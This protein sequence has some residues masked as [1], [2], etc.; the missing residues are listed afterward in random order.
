M[1]QK[2]T[3]DDLNKLE[4]YDGAPVQCIAVYDPTF[5]TFNSEHMLDIIVK[6]FAEKYEMT[7]Y[8]APEYTRTTYA[9]AGLS[10]TFLY[11][12]PSGDLV[13][14]AFLKLRRATFP[15]LP[16]DVNDIISKHVGGEK[17]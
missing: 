13:E 7:Y 2:Y 10:N 1:K 4:Y 5:L 16:H 9:G 14:E 3:F 15:L 11:A 8:P 6:Y 12:T 17:W